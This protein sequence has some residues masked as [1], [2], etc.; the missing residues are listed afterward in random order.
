[1]NTGDNYQPR[2][3]VKFKTSTKLWSEEVHEDFE[4]SELKA[5][6]A[7]VLAVHTKSLFNLNRFWFV[8]IQ[9]IKLK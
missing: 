8:S 5:I 2:Y 7:D 9:H 4:L 6:L 1:M 3:V